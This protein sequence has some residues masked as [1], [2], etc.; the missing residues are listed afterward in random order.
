ML[1]RAVLAPALVP[2]SGLDALAG[3]LPP[4]GRRQ[5]YGLPA[6]DSGQLSPGYGSSVH[7][8][9]GNSGPWAAAG[10]RRGLAGRAAATGSKGCSNRLSETVKVGV[11][12]M[13]MMETASISP[14][15]RMV[16]A[17]DAL[18]RALC[19]GG[20]LR[21]GLEG[22][23]GRA[24]PS[25]PEGIRGWCVGVNEAAISWKCHDA[26][27]SGGRRGFVMV[28]WRASSARVYKQTRTV[29]LGWCNVRPPSHPRTHPFRG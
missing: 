15:A 7:A 6:R 14:N 4:M 27:V 19:L 26:P 17:L 8:V 12:L 22:T 25:L 24:R 13:R 18:D 20:Y 2:G 11:M 16:R 3:P 1:C 28:R 9:A 5:T 10:A 23:C 29:P 21:V